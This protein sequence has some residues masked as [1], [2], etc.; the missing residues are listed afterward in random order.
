MHSSL[1]YKLAQV[2]Q[3]DSAFSEDSIAVI[4]I[5]T[6][7]SLRAELDAAR[8]K[9]KRLTEKQ[10][11]TCHG[12]RWCYEPTYRFPCPECNMQDVAPEKP[13]EPPKEPI[14]KHICLVCMGTGILLGCQCPCGT[15]PK[16]EPQ[17]PEPV[18]KQPRPAN[19]PKC[20]IKSCPCQNQPEQPPPEPPTKAAYEW[21]EVDNPPEWKA[22][23]A[24]L[25]LFRNSCAAGKIMATGGSVLY[26]VYPNFIERRNEH[27]T[28]PYL[29]SSVESAKAAVEAVVRAHFGDEV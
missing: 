21:V 16:S 26:F 15:L 4:A 13:P 8:E 5:D 22:K 18:K 17:Q 11:E 19:L 10:C 27:D 9:V 28:Q 29:A 7:D 2:L 3:V 6:L 14:Y 20:S 12:R 25:T 1:R 23:Q 24:T